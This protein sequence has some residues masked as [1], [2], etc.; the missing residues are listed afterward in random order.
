MKL[1]RAQGTMFLQLPNNPPQYTVLPPRRKPL[2]IH[3]NS[4]FNEQNNFVWLQI[5]IVSVMLHAKSDPDVLQFVK[6]Y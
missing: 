1:P 3:E 5:L 2:N 6:K 4:I